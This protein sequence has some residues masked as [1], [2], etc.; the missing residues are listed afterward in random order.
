MSFA[1]SLFLPQLVKK[2]GASTSFSTYLDPVLSFINRGT[3][4]F[5]FYFI[6]LQQMSLWL[7]DLCAYI[8]YDVVLFVRS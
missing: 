8:N 4:R 6:T 3:A 5:Y 7:L 1:N 2:G